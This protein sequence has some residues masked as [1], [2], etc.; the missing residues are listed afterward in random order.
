MLVRPEDLSA[1]MRAGRGGDEGAYRLLLEA[2]TVRLR[3]VVKNGLR[4][5][6]RGEQDIEDVVQEALL[7]IHL[8][9]HTWDESQ[10]LE[11]WVRAI[12]HHK[13]VD[14]LRRRGFRQHVDIDDYSDELSVPASADNDHARECADLLAALTPR[15]REL[16]EAI[17]IEGHSAREV[18]ERL[19]LSEGA[20]RVAL[21]RALKAMAA[22]RL[23]GEA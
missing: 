22:A 20:V 7:A 8:K 11:P 19:G 23:R 5:Y 16:V 6:G 9:R 2:L 3:I 13:L 15:Q 17:S 4:R 21:H 1:L 18:G 10:P 12:A 14:S